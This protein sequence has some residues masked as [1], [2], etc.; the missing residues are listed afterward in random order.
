MSAADAVVADTG[1]ILLAGGRG[2]RMGGVAKPL[3]EVGGRSLVQRAVDAVAGCHPI[4]I[5][6][7][8]L[9]PG[10]RGVEWT[11]EEPPFGGPAAGVA[12]ALTGWPTTRSPTWTFVLASDLVQPDAV[13]A[14]LAAVRQQLDPASDGAH[15]VDADGHAQWL[16]GLYRTSALRD[17]VAGLPDGAPGQSMRA[18]LPGLALTPV[19]APAPTTRDIDTWED[20]DRARA[21][22]APLEDR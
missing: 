5:V 11:R 21:D 12:A 18:L 1:A 19:P 20:L 7:D 16:A 6:A 22:A 2:L 15:L 3:L 8:V 10:I 4:T 17:A 9:D 13:V 14:T